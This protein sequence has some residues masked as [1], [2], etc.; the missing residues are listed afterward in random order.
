M[1]NNEDVT[2][3]ALIIEINQKTSQLHA[4]L[5]SL[6]T[7][8]TSTGKKLLTLESLQEKNFNKNLENF[9]LNYAIVENMI[10]I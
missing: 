1:V 7:I 9:L 5:E 4:Q 2:E 8:T 10:I 6:T 3:E